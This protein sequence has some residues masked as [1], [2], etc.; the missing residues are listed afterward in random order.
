MRGRG[1]LC[2]EADP[3]VLHFH[4]RDPATK[5]GGICRRLFEY[6]GVDV[7]ETRRCYDL[8]MVDG[9]LVANLGA[10]EAAVPE[11]VGS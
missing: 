9:V 10:F 2:G 11:R 4:H 7:S 1:R 8:D 3:V 5:G 6:Y